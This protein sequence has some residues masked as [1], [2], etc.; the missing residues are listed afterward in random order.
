MVSLGI[1]CLLGSV[2]IFSRDDEIYSE[3]AIRARISVIFFSNI[4]VGILSIV[5]VL[6]VMTWIR[7]MFYRHRDAGMY[8]S[9]SLGIALGT[10]EQWFIAMSC[11]LFCVV[12]L[13][14]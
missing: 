10:A 6:P 14:S 7:D 5:S 2:F 4:I 9:A 3:A 8:D 1:A 13:S 11:A 12:F